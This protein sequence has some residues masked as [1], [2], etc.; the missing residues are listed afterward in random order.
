MPIKFLHT[1][2]VALGR[3]IARLPGK[4]I[5]LVS[6]VLLLFIIV[7]FIRSIGTE[8]PRKPLEALLETLP[9][10]ENGSPLIIVS[11]VKGEFPQGVARLFADS[12]SMS[13][14]G[15]SPVVLFLPILD[16]AD[17]MSLV[18][19]EREEGL[20]MYGV[21]PLTLEE[22]DILTS[23]ELPDSWKSYFVSPELL[24]TDRKGLYRLHA[25]NIT[26]PLYVE[27]EDDIAFVADS[28]YDVDRIMS[29]RN[30]LS[31][32]VKKKWTLETEWGGHI[33]LSDGG[34]LR[35]MLSGSF[36]P[37]SPINALE[38][39]LAWNTSDDQRIGQ[40]R[41]QLG[42]AD[43]IVSRVFLNALKK[44]DWSELDIFIPDPLILSLG[45]NLPNPGRNIAS[46]PSGFRYLAD[47]MRKMGMK[48][49]EVQ[50]ILT[51]PTTFSLG[52]RTQLLWFD[53]PGIV[54][55]LPARG[56]VSFKLI[57]KFWSEL[58]TG[59]EPRAVP[60]YPNG[61]VADLPFTVM[62]VGNDEKAVFGL[63]DPEAEQNYEIR[64]LLAN[65]TGAV[66]WM[67]L[68][69]P[70]FGASLAEIPALNSMIYE[71]ESGPL[72][73]ESAT[74]LKDAMTA[75][76]RVFVTFDSPTSGTALCYY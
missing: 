31:G 67:Y 46:L 8:G 61:G 69:F 41:W 54:V 22:S 45:V 18:I 28:L 52:G 29:V 37:P 39:E 59:S 17:A 16:T 65:T 56:D 23:G 63:T 4:K 20:A 7:I 13:S 19:T 14:G 24:A 11:A 76:G 53:L 30:G 36:E 51:G 2:F 1:P 42:G 72:D 34:V 12:A 32:G 40:A 26:S 33:F 9:E 60:G 25:R 43:N 58:F 70:R 48:N 10:T 3:Y 50:T 21:F 5:T 57:D 74:H 38:V 62:A 47:H 66:A 35:S 73:E 75:L 49:A 6:L 27:L 64:E 71:D 68:D 44:Q 15:M 55:D